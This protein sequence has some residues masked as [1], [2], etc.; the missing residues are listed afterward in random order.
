[1][2]QEAEEQIESPDEDEETEEGSVSAP[3]PSVTFPWLMLCVAILFDSVGMIPIV[4]FFSEA[5]AGLTFGL[6]QKLY[7]PKANPLITFIVAKIADAL[8]LGFLPSNIAIV[9][10]AY[11]KKKVESKIPASKLQESAAQPA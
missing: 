10:F 2:P 4:N 9:I 1:M 8:C 5:I 11:M 3:P 7:S 6:W